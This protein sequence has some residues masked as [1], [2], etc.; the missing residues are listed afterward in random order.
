MKLLNTIQPVYLCIWNEGSNEH[1]IVELH[2]QGSFFDEYK[3]TNLFAT[4]T[5]DGFLVSLDK[6]NKNETYIDDN[7]SIKRIY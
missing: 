2:T 6:L 7:M 3:N 5:G 4:D 1:E